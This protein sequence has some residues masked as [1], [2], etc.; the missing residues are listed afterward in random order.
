MFEY[1]SVSMQECIHNIHV[2]TYVYNFPHTHKIII[3]SPV[4]MVSKLHSLQKGCG[5]EHLI[6]TMIELKG[7][8]YPQHTRSRSKTCANHV[9]HLMHSSCATCHVLK[10]QLSFDRVQ[11]AFISALFF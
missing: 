9:Q 2:C 11:I 6:I 8:N 4:E 1:D 5:L 3:L 10:G 7:T